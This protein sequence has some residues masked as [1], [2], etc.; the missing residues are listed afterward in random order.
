MIRHIKLKKSKFSIYLFNLFIIL[1]SCKT[2]VK[3]DVKNEVEINS[4]TKN[5]DSS[6]IINKESNLDSKIGKTA[7]ELVEVKQISNNKSQDSIVSRLKSLKVEID[8]NNIYINNSSAKYSNDKSDSKQFFGKNYVYNYYSDYLFKNYKIDIKK[9]VNYIEISYEDAQRYPF[10]D[11]FLE[12]GVTVFMNDYLFLQYSDYIIT[13]K[14]SSKNPSEKKLLVALPFDY[15]KYSEECYL[16]DNAKCNEKYPRIVGNELKLVTTLINKKINKNKPEIIYH[17]DNGG[18]PFVTYF[19]QIRDEKTDYFLNSMIINIKNGELIAKEQIG[20]QANGDIP[21][22]VDYMTKS[23][24]LNKDLTIN[25]FE[26][27]FSKIYKKLD[28][29][30]KINSDGNI[31]LQK[32]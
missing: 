20:L 22:S 9:D 14:K 21:E 7:L 31:V 32:K 10:K 16:D 18:L 13:F 19:F 30:Y 12:G 25:I 24:V 28:E 11:F 8:E 3:A 29:T 1:S 17:L 27:R 2:D 6:S 4:T 5:V 26:I 15:Q 23:F